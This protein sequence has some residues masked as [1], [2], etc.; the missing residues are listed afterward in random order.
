MTKKQLAEK[1]FNISIE[2][3]NRQDEAVRLILK[4]LKERN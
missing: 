2:W 4:E 3:Q 1:L